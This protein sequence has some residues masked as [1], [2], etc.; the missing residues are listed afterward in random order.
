MRVQFKTHI[1]YALLCK[2]SGHSMLC[3]Y[4]PAVA[5]TEVAITKPHCTYYAFQISKSFLSF[6][7]DK[8][9][10]DILEQDTIQTYEKH[11]FRKYVIFA[12]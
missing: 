6:L 1:I 12:M 4:K 2:T 10:S 3:R 9:I 11:F 5:V 8:D 7:S